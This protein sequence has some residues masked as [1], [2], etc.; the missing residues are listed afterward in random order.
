[1]LKKINTLLACFIAFVATSQAQDTLPGFTIRD[2]GQNRVAISWVNRFESCIQL[3]VQRSFDSSRNFRTFFS[4]P[5]PEL[6]QNGIVDTK[7]PAPN[8]FYRIFYVLQGGAYFFTPAKRI[9]AGFANTGILDSTGTTMVTIK[10]SDSILTRIPY[11][12]YKKFRDSIIYKTKDSL[13]AIGEDEI[14]IKPFIPQPPAWRP[15]IYLFTNREGYVI[16]HL[17]DAPQKH[18]KVIIYDSDGKVLHTINRVK[19]PQLTLD[20]S[21]FIH[22]GWFTF[23]VFEDSK[24]KEH[25]KFY[26]A[27]EF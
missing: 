8:M 21:D 1:M 11:A 15:S 22:A 13:F 12:Q 25:N 10:K 24:L 7:A 14:I 3:N 19:E 16:M 5:S 20:K 9:P 4:T 6:P 26:I 17:P 27:K 2:L 23:D 18:Y